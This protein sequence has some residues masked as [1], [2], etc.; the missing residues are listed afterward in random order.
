MVHFKRG[1]LSIACVCMV[2]GFMLAVQFRSTQDI[3]ASVPYQRVEDL[4]ARLQ[5]SEKDK[6]A[7]QA[8]LEDIKS[9][10]GEEQ[11]NKIGEDLR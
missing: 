9:R 5:Q 4:S 7:L 8:E 6:D 11:N 1:R 2:L 10:A 3:K